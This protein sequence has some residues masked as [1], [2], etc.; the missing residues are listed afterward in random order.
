MEVNSIKTMSDEES[1]KVSGILPAEQPGIIIAMET[2]KVVE[3]EGRDAKNLIA[4][5]L[6]NR[7]DFISKKRTSLSKIPL[8]KSFTTKWILSRK[9]VA[10]VRSAS[11]G[12][13]KRSELQARYWALL[14]GNLQ[15]VIN[16]IYQT[17][18]CYENL[19]SCQETILVLEN[20]IRDFK[21]LAEWF[22]VSWDYEAMPQRPQSLAWEV[23]KSNPVPL[24]IR[25]KSLSSPSPTLGSNNSSPS[26]SF[27][28][29][30]FTVEETD[31]Q[32][33]SRRKLLDLI[34]GCND[35]KMNK[36]CSMELNA[37]KMSAKI[38]NIDMKRQ[39]MVNITE[40]HSKK[41][42]VNLDNPI[43]NITSGRKT[44]DNI[45]EFESKTENYSQTEYIITD[46]FDGKCDQ[47]SQTD[48]DDENLTLEQWNQKYVDTPLNMSNN[49]E[50][51]ELNRVTEN[52]HAMQTL[53][54]CIQLPSSGVKSTIEPKS[55]NVISKC[56]S[57]P[58][59]SVGNPVNKPIF[60]TC[61]LKKPRSFS[62]QKCNTVT[63]NYVRKP[64]QN[65][66]VRTHNK[67]IINNFDK[68]NMSS[69]STR[70][71]PTSLHTNV[72]K[73]L[74]SRSKTMVEITNRNNRI[75]DIQIMSKATSRQGIDNSTSILKV[76]PQS[77]SDLVGDPLHRDQL[78]CNLDSKTLPKEDS[79]GWLTVKVK[80]RTSLHWANR[81]N[82]PS[83]SAS[84]P[85]LALKGNEN[86]F[87]QSENS[88]FKDETVELKLTQSKKDAKKGV[89]NTPIPLKLSGNSSQQKRSLCNST[90]NYT[91]VSIPK[92]QNIK[93][94][95]ATN[96]C[97]RFTAHN[98]TNK[99]EN[100]K[101][102]LVSPITIFSRTTGPPNEKSGLTGLK[103]TTLRKEYIRSI[104]KNQDLRSPHN[105][106]E[107]IGKSVSHDL[108]DKME[109]PTNVDMHIPANV[110]LSK[111]MCDLYVSYNETA[112]TKITAELCISSSDELDDKDESDDD[113]RKLLEEQESLERQI[114]ELENTE[115]DVDTET[116]ETDCDAILDMKD[117]DVFSGQ[118]DIT[119]TNN[120]DLSLEIRYQSLLSEMSLGER[121][122]TLATLQAIVSRHPG[123]AQE[124]HQK[125]SSPSRCRSLHETLKKYQSK[126]TRA[127]AKRETLNKE[128]AQKIQSLL[129]RVEDVKAAKQQLIANKR[130][131]MEERLQ[132]A[133]DNRTQYLKD[134]I[135]KAHDEEEKMKEIAFI[136]SLEAQNKRLDFI[137]SWKEQEGRLLDLEQERQKKV[138]EKAAKEAAVEKRR[139]E[140]ELE[141]RRK[142]EKMNE[143][144]K[145][146]EQRIGEMQEKREK[147]RQQTARNKAR[148]REER[149]LALQA[150][151][152]HSTEE[153]QRKIFQKQQESAR[154]HEENI[155]HIRQRALELSIPSRCFDENGQRIESAESA[156]DG[157]L[158]SIVSD[159][160]P[161]YTSK[162]VKRRLK[163]INQKLQQKTEEYFSSLEQVPSYMKRDSE[164]PKLLSIIKKGGGSQGI[165]RPLGQLLR[166]MAKVQVVDYQCFWLLDGLCVIS[167]IIRNVADPAENEIS[168]RAIIIAIQI[169]RNSCSQC[170]QIARHAILG[171]SY[172]NL[173]DALLQSLQKQD[174]KTPLHPVELST[175]LMLACISP[176][177]TQTQPHPKFVDRLPY[178][179]R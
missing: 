117:N 32:R 78:N 122:E 56:G 70:N 106:L 81:F 41:L 19:S 162:S 126:Q 26:P 97:Q 82:F 94:S 83:G 28:E 133:A 109:Y 123:R 9:P 37:S 131:R 125:L 173:C 124:L 114:R 108:H 55:F 138:E 75:R 164:V 84:L 116:D 135:R 53:N 64:L 43:D 166:I 29:N 88:S 57:L 22:R 80:R 159:V 16:E 155:E 50:N 175:E 111:A 177:H 79:D 145:E 160:S 11:T 58:I 40:M 67:S 100:S 8:K 74:P 25:A 134:K 69:N 93:N 167:K 132:R 121:V 141:R 35:S 15:R 178:V 12:R 23:R 96:K 6:S 171:N 36:L 87:E 2:K 148:D 113:Q 165:E 38:N 44:C 127:Q 61:S 128:K 14:F 120:D 130:H 62:Q 24:R 7:D 66:A 4:Y 156:G 48:L 92:L 99:I 136:K 91:K 104:N 77:G 59:R 140:L 169:Y 18:E 27:S 105:N 139:Q 119:Q 95:D 112:N 33:T 137:E 42:Y 65:F 147:L 103:L 172:T 98:F 13:D 102:N 118:F 3:Q 52:D 54:A 150:Q 86:T 161:E 129:A 154:R 170:P 153:L 115:I 72:N 45:Q 60:T 47:Y 143:T 163:K 51:I 149:L 174:E 49:L 17:V 168:R 34:T 179:I 90:N 73:T 5:H 176:F 39:E 152:Q 157:D 146:R 1:Q 20:Y 151:Q 10:R 85:S 101:C 30:S 107:T 142:L 76:S 68:K 89:E 110:G 158:S 21:A 144:R 71:D 31:I 46:S 63:K